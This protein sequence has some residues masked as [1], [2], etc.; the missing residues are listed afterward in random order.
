MLYTFMV[1]RYAYTMWLTACLVV[2]FLCSHMSYSCLT[3]LDLPAVRG[4][5]SFF[6][7]PG[8]GLVDGQGAG[9][10]ADRGQVK[11]MGGQAKLFVG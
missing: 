10:E 4:D 2:E 11:D 1:V 5:S 3:G 6:V 9:T 7:S 8:P